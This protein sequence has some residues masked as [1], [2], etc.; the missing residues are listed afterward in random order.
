MVS[1]QHSSVFFWNAT[2][3]S[4]FQIRA[5]A[6]VLLST[7]KPSV[8]CMVYSNTIYMSTR[9]GVVV[10]AGPDNAAGCAL[11]SSMN[12]ANTNIIYAIE[13]LGTKYKYPYH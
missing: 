4:P 1:G 9:T 12:T 7:Q 5:L 3:N 10:A 2:T 8:S 11:K 13:N 6:S